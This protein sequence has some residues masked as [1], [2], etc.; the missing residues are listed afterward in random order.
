[1]RSGSLKRGVEC[2]LTTHRAPHQPG[3]RGGRYGLEHGQQ[4]INVPEGFGGGRHL[5][6][7]SP[8]IRDDVAPGGTEPLAHL[9][10]PAPVAHARVK[11]GDGGAGALPAIAEKRRAR[12]RDL[13]RR[14]LHA[15]SL[16]PPPRAAFFQP[17]T[18]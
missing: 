18:R 14:I 15:R 13:E 11:E 10:P 2:H 4:I 9:A 5:T 1:M 6:E 12:D 16:L 7:P 17:R 3:R 8:I